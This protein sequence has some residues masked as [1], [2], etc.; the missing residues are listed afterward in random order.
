MHKQQHILVIDDDKKLGNLLKSFLN[1]KGYLV[2][3]AENTAAAKEMMFNI[4]FDL[5]ILDVML[6]K[7]S[8]LTFATNIRKKY[9]TPILMLS[10][11]GN[12]SDRIKG[13]RTGADEYLSKPFE[14]EELML[15]I[16]NV[17]KRNKAIKQEINSIKIGI[18]NFDVIKNFLSKDSS[19]VK[20]TIKETKVLLYLYEKLGNDVKREELAK[21]ID[22][23]IRT[24]DVLVKRLREKISSLPSSK[25]IL[26]T[27]RGIGYKLDP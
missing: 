1:E 14:P 6:P 7:E 8:G 13:L 4:I 27:S 24:V 17:V 22:V 18:F 10:A 16:E 15:R 12:P 11:M 3:V 20:L 9:N 19:S 21:E 5:L 26:L 2:D 23:S 25:N